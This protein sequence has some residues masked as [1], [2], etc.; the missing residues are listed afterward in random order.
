MK[1]T[2]EPI[3]D[4]AFILRIHPDLDVNPNLYVGSASVTVVERVATIRGL[5]VLPGYSMYRTHRAIIDELARNGVD[6]RHHERR[7]N[8]VTRWVRREIGG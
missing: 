3:I 5:V 7:T 4:P 8:G 1:A 6:M 2:L